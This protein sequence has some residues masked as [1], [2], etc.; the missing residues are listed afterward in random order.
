MNEKQWDRPLHFT[1]LMDIMD[2]QHPKPFDFD[3]ARE[4]WKLVEFALVDTPVVAVL[5]LVDQTFQVGERD[6]V[7][8]LCTVYFI[9]KAG[10]R[11]LAA[12]EGKGI[13]WYENLEGGFRGHVVR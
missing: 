1:P 3:V 4:H 9:R 13:I 8:P 6:A 5:P 12:K 10:I 7:V 11:K 2:I